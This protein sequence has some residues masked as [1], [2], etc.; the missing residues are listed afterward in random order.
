M[1]KKF[2]ELVKEHHA[3]YEVPPYCVV[4]EE[5]EGR[6]SA[7]GRITQAGLDVDI[8]G[9]S[10]SNKMMPPGPDPDYAL[11]CADLEEIAEKISHL[12]GDPCAVEV[13]SFGSRV[14][15]DTHQ[16]APEGMLRIRISRRGPDQRAGLP[17]QD[18]LKEVEAQLR[19]LGLARR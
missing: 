17:E 3:F 13:I 9:I 8:Y 10:P 14:V 18:A 6:R 2:H 16:A 1:N 15:I 7:A 12:T 11:G 19:G 4:L 5:K